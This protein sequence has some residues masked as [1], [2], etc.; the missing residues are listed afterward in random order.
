MAW[1]YSL[2]YQILVVDNGKSSNAINT[3][4][5]SVIMNTHYRS[6]ICTVNEVNSEYNND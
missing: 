6:C 5:T 4:G 1:K 3:H 2:F